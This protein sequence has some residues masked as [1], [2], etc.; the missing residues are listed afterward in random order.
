MNWTRRIWM[1]RYRWIE[2]NLNLF[3]LFLLLLK[4]VRMPRKSAQL[5]VEP[6]YP[7]LAIQMLPTKP[8]AHRL[9][10]L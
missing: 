2:I 3:L 10:A 4:Y 5:A 7:Y 1:S 6:C 9:A 8:L